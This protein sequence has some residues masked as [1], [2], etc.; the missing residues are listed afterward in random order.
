M[1]TVV[2]GI[3]VS[4]LRLD[5]CSTLA[6]SP[7]PNTVACVNCWVHKNKNM[8]IFAERTLD[9]DR[10]ES[11]VNPDLSLYSFLE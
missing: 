10:Y 3:S 5:A 2:A 6:S 7:W 9:Y 4:C 11:D 1:V 8:N